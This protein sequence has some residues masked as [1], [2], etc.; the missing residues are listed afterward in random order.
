[1]SKIIIINIILNKWLNSSI[2][3]IDETLPGTINLAKSG[4]ESNDNERV[5]HIAQ[6][7]RNGITLFNAVECHTQETRWGGHLPVCLFAVFQSIHLFISRI[8]SILSIYL[9][10]YLSVCLSVLFQLIYL[11]LCLLVYLFISILFHSI[12]FQ[13]FMCFFF[14][15]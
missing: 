6:S 10:I 7:S 15:D 5:L 9:S 13:W 12:Y 8:S 11:T 1:M 4:L 3:H 2:W 14:Q